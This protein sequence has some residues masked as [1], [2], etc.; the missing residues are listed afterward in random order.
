MRFFFS[1]LFFTFILINHSARG[2]YKTDSLISQ[3][4]SELNNK[5]FFDKNKNTTI[6]RLKNKLANAGNN[7]SRQYYLCDKIYHEYKSYQ[8]DSAYTYVRKMQ[9]ISRGLKDKKKQHE[10]NVKLGF[11]LL[12]SGM[13]TETF[14]S[15]KNVDVSALSDSAKIDYYSMLTRAYYDLAAYDNDKYYAPL[16]NRLAN[17]YIDSAINTA[18][19]GSFNKVYLLAY[20][21]LKIGDN[22]TAES[23]LL[24]ILKHQKLNEH[25][26]AI[27][28]S[29]LANIYKA[30][31][32]IEQTIG[33][34]AEAA[35]ADIRSSTKET[36]ALFWLSEILYKR[37]DINYIQHAMADAE[38]Y[39]ARQRKFQI[40]AVLPIVAAEKLNNSEREKTR[41]LIYFI[42]I[43]FLALLVVLFSIVLFKQ[44]KKLKAKEKIIEETNAKLEEINQK[45]IEGTRIKEEYIGY[46][47]NVISG[48]IL[49]LDKLKRSI[50]M[51]LSVKKYDD[52]GII[53]N[54]I[55]IKKERESGF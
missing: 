20:K 27:V 29:T 2:S 52:I 26:F 43:T 17:R 12:S 38:F 5:S 39:G 18:G 24:A 13:F 28:A 21:S 37:G 54:N 41:F 22:K 32:Q 9:S 45:L 6:N 44:L 36:I 25:E 23:Q 31:N 34:L 42:S 4:N 10:S 33:L 14:E 7:L 15:L 53:I 35:I 30:N 50:D 49:K 47:F 51:K 55:N 46:F 16:Y 11:I 8:F 48:Y 40:S 1:L 19:P 3:L